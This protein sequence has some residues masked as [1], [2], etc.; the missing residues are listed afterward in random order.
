MLAVVE[1]HP[2]QY[3]APVY[4][5]LQK[6][7]GIPVT[8]IYGSD[9]SLNEYKDS[10]F[11]ASFK[12]DSD[13]TSGYNSVFLSRASKGGA[14]AFETTSAAG[15]QSVLRKLRPKALLILG[16]SHR[17]NQRAFYESWKANYPILFRGETTD[18]AIRRSRLKALVRDRSLRWSYHHS[19]R[20]LY[21][22]QRS[23]QHYKR[24]NCPE[25]KLVFSPYCVD[26]S[27][28]QTDETARSQM[29]F[30]TR[31]ELGVEASEV[32]I[33]FSGKLSPRKGPDLLLE[34]LKLLPDNVR[35]RVTV[36][37]MGSGELTSSLKAYASIDP[38]LKVKFL[39][40]Q[41]QSQLSRYY[42]AADLLVL[43]S[44][45]GETWGLVVNEALHHGLPCVVSDAVGCAPD[46]VSEN[47]T[48]Y[49]FKSGSAS[50]L[51]AAITKALALVDREDIRQECRQRVSMYSV[52]N[53]AAGIACAYRQVVGH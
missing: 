31:A 24:L 19:A 47:V 42:H 36:V 34:G 28:F 38:V 39:G 29:R 51:S 7:F 20:L 35:N 40:F 44:R 21:I 46:L 18:H 37:F 9:F 3:H 25:Q 49:S 15:L 11:G 32:V 5:A 2:V 17:F 12:W 52:T 30:A 8:A 16:Y 13:L 45:E 6:E 23:Y 27:T 50:S 22:G 41:N 53:A 33:I 4:R 48:G 26:E 14:A 10:E 1:T 43:P